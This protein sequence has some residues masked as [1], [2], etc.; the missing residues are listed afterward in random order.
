MRDPEESLGLEISFIPTC[1]GREGPPTDT[2]QQA[3]V[4][5]GRWGWQWGAMGIPGRW[6]ENPRFSGAMRRTAPRARR[7]AETGREFGRLPWSRTESQVRAGAL[8]GAGGRGLLLG[9]VMHRKKS[10]RPVR[11]HRG[12]EQER[13]PLGLE[14]VTA[15]DWVVPG[16][17]LSTAL[18]PKAGF[19]PTLSHPLRVLLLLGPAAPEL[20]GDEAR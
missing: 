7:E 10:I 18:A 13:K 17:A 11:G 8:E 19:G 12:P 6:R 20:N 3:N 15:R 5:A 9:M 1:Q 4:R 2:G 14:A 16:C